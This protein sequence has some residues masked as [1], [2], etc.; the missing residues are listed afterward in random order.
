MNLN[1][2]PLK[3]KTKRRGSDPLGGGSTARSNPQEAFLGARKRRSGK[4]TIGGKD[5]FLLGMQAVVLA[6]L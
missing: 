4:P 6:N 1:F 3:F 2:K 5:S